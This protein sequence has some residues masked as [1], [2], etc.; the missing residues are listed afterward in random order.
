MSSPKPPPRPDSETAGRRL[1]QCRVLG[2]LGAGAAGEALLAYD[3]RLDR[4]VA[5]KRIRRSENATA[6]ER[7]RFL[8]EARAVAHLTHPA[9]V[10]IYEIL[11]D[12]NG[13]ALVMECV[14]GE[15]MAQKLR[16]GPF[17]ISDILHLAHEIA[18]ALAEAHGK[19]IIHRDL[20]AEN[21]MVTE[22][23][24]AKILD[25]G[26]AKV[27]RQEASDDPSLTV[28]G[29]VLG[30]CRSMSPEQATGL[31]I[32]ERSD[33]FSV[34][35]LLFEMATGTSPFTGDSALQTLANVVHQEP[36]SVRALRPDVPRSLSMAISQLLEKEPENRPASA[37][38]LADELARIARETASKEELTRSAGDSLDD[39]ATGS[40]SAYPSTPAV[41]PRHRF[42]RRWTAWLGLAAVLVAVALAVT[43]YRMRPPEPVRVAV[44][45]PRV[46]DDDGGELELVAAAVLDGTLEALIA[47][48]GVSPV[49]PDQIGPV[50][51]GPAEIARAVAA[52]QVLSAAIEGEEGLARVTLRKI[53]GDGQTLWNRTFKVPRSPNDARVVAEGVGLHLR[54]AFPDHPAAGDGSW[55]EVRDED[56]A[57]FLRA[58]LRIDSGNVTWQAELDELERIIAGS[59][60]FLEARLLAADTATTLFTDTREPAYLQRATGFLKQSRALAPTDP[61]PLY[62]DFRLA[63][64]NGETGRAEQVLAE[65]ERRAPHDH[66]VPLSRARLAEKQGD[67]D[68]AVTAMRAVIERHPSWRHLYRIASLEIERGEPEAARGY[69]EELLRRAPGNTWGLGKLVHL[70]LSVGE[71]EMAEQTAIALLEIKRHRSYLNNLGFIRFLLGRYEEAKT[72]YLEAL[73]FS[74]GHPMVLLNLADAESALGRKAAAAA[75]YR[76][77]LEQ[78]ERREAAAPLS[79]TEE[80]NRAQCL[81][82]LGESRRAV[83]ITLKVLKQ[84]GE[85]ADIAYQAALVY[86]L[87]GENHS[88]VAKAREALAGKVERRLFAIPGFDSLRQDPEFQAMLAPTDT[89]RP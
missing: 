29:T 81:A 23:G 54:D 87:T 4:R 68:G 88:A 61:R 45:A 6:V 47:F 17:E 56:Y 46:Q 89:G 48:Q 8:R 72:S 37:A 14:E 62:H 11:E 52:D 27:R 55:L 43:A 67:L 30:T 35:V 26:L 38:D 2:L 69:L 50:T 3:D 31:K 64:E 84:H 77:S 7:Q 28:A 86:A 1:G 16:D 53:A 78:L 58:K 83:E 32:D 75:L 79:V 18:E 73:E 19:G 9:I 80:M 34:G 24:H 49:D 51:G 63:L 60:N 33:L 74:P 85:S 57:D 36:P 82:R 5:I 71:L 65:L 41:R 22:H 66:L 12:E 76:Q 44:P 25:F 20:K 10:Q 15:T 13:D 39:A 21:V 40:V 59:P 42:G 70:E